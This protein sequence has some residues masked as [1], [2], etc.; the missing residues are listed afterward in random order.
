MKELLKQIAVAEAIA[1]AAHRDLGS[2]GR[3][4][5]RCETNNQP[6]PPNVPTKVDRLNG[7]LNQFCAKL[8]PLYTERDRL[9]AE[10]KAKAEGEATLRQTLTEMAR[11]KGRRHRQHSKARL[12]TQA[13]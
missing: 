13:A 5:K 2:L 7:E 12:V 9:A 11:G 8:A 6:V 1:L 10:I 4:I 3:L